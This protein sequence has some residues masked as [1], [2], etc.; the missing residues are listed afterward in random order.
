[1][2]NKIPQIHALG[3][4]DYGSK[5][6]V[7]LGDV[8]S[9]VPAVL[10]TVGKL[11]TNVIPG[12]ITYGVKEAV[13]AFA[14]Q[15]AQNNVSLYDW[16]TKSGWVAQLQGKIDLGA[17]AGLISMQDPYQINSALDLLAPGYNPSIAKK[18]GQDTALTRIAA[19]LDSY[20]R[21]ILN[22]MLKGEFSK[23]GINTLM[24]LGEGFNMLANL[25]KAPLAF[26]GNPLYRDA[27]FEDYDTALSYVSQVAQG[28][29][30]TVYDENGDVA[31]YKVIDPKT[32]QIKSISTE[33]YKS[34]SLI[35][36]TG[37][38]ANI[39][40]LNVWERLASSIGAGDNGRIEYNFDSGSL[41]A[42][43]IGE[44]AVDPSTWF[45]FGL[46]SLG[47]AG[48]KATRAG[49]KDALKIAGS[50]SDEIAAGIMRVGEDRI[51]AAANKFLAEK[52]ISVAAKSSIAPVLERFL[53]DA[54]NDAAT[55]SF[56]IKNFDDAFNAAM[57]YHG[58]YTKATDM[59]II[60]LIN[61]AKATQRARMTNT[62]LRT[63]ETSNDV[64]GKVMWW[65]GG[66]TTGLA[67]TVKLLRGT[68]KA[69]AHKISQQ[70]DAAVQPYLDKQGACNIMCYDDVTRIFDQAMD[71]AAE[72][73]NPS[74]LAALNDLYNKGALFEEQSNRV[75]AQINSIVASKASAKEQLEQLKTVLKDAYDTTSA[76]KVVAQYKRVIKQFPDAKYLQEAV[77]TLEQ[78]AKL[79]KYLTKSAKYGDAHEIAEYIFTSLIKE[80]PADASKIYQ[81]PIRVQ[82]SNIREAISDA[83]TQYIGDG[84]STVLTPLLVRR[85]KTTI[86]E[87][88]KNAY[89]SE[90]QRLHDR[91]LKILPNEASVIKD[92]FHQYTYPKM[93]NDY[94]Q[95]IDNIERTLDEK[96]GISLAEFEPVL[97]KEL[98][99]VDP[100]VNTVYRDLIT[101]DAE[102]AAAA[103]EKF[104]EWRTLVMQNILATK[105]D[106]FVPASLANVQKLVQTANKAQQKLL[107]T[108][109]QLNKDL[110]LPAVKKKGASFERPDLQELL[111]RAADEA[112]DTGALEDVLYSDQVF[113]TE[114]YELFD[115]EYQIENVEAFFSDNI[116][117]ALI[118]P[119]KHVS[120]AELQ[121]YLENFKSIE[122]QVQQMRDALNELPEKT[123]ETM[124]EYKKQGWKYTLRDPID[125][126]PNPEGHALRLAQLRRDVFTLRAEKLQQAEA[127][128][129]YYDI[130]NY[131]LDA[132]Q[133]VLFEDMVE[134]KLTQIA[135]TDMLL[136][137]TSGLTDLVSL[138]SS[139]TF[140]KFVDNLKVVKDS[141]TELYQALNWEVI[142]KGVAAASQIRTQVPAMIALRN[143][144][145]H[146]IGLSDEQAIALYNAIT[147]RYYLTPDQVATSYTAQTILEDA[148]KNDMFTNHSTRRLSL[149]EVG[150]RDPETLNKLRAQNGFA[151]LEDGV[152]E[153]HIAAEDSI[154][155]FM[156][157][158]ELMES[159]SA[160][161]AAVAGKRTVF[162]DIETQNEK[163][164]LQKNQIHSVAIME[165][166]AA[167]NIVKR[168][169]IALDAGKTTVNVNHAMLGKL[170]PDLDAGARAEQ[171]IASLSKQA[172]DGL[173]KDST[174]LARAA[175]NYLL[176][177]YDAADTCIIGHNIAAFDAP[178]LN[179][180]VN[181]IRYD[182]STQLFGY[183]TVDTYTAARG[184]YAA[185][186]ISFTTEQADQITA[187]LQIY[188]HQLQQSDVT[189]VFTPITTEQL[190]DLKNMFREFN[191]HADL[192]S[193][194]D[195]ELFNAAKKP[196]SKIGESLNMIRTNNAGLRSV[197]LPKQLFITGN[198]L[199]EEQLQKLVSGWTEYF[200][201]MGMSAEDITAR[202]GDS[203]TALSTTSILGA[204]DATRS[205]AVKNILS[206]DMIKQ[207]FN[208][209][210]HLV[211]GYMP[212][213]TAM[214]LQ[215]TA[216]SL[217]R[218]EQ[219]FGALLNVKAFSPDIR[220]QYLISAD[221][222]YARFVNAESTLFPELKDIL[223]YEQLTD[224]QK[225]AVASYI[226]DRAPGKLGL[227]AEQ[228]FTED[229]IPAGPLW[230]FANRSCP[231]TVRYS[232]M[233]SSLEV[234]R[235]YKQ[236]QI[237]FNANKITLDQLAEIKDA[238][239]CIGAAH[240]VRMRALEPLFDFID[241][242]GSLEGKALITFSKIDIDAGLRRSKLLIADVLHTPPEQMKTRLA[243][244]HGVIRI[245]THGLQMQEV[246]EMLS[247]YDTPALQAAGVYTY[248]DEQ[249]NSIWFTLDAKAGINSTID[250]DLKRARIYTADGTELEPY[251]FG[252]T[253][254]AACYGAVKN[255]YGAKLIDTE[256]FEAAEATLISATDGALIG[257]DYTL[258]TAERLK[259]LYESMPKQVRE[260]YDYNTFSKGAFFKT[261]A[262]NRSDLS[263]TSSPLTVKLYDAAQRTME[264]A[265]ADTLY[266]QCMFSDF[267]AI[268][269]S[270]I[271]GNLIRNNPADVA[272][273]F[274]KNGAYVGASLATRRDGTV[275][276]KTYDLGNTAELQACLKEGGQIFDYTEYAQIYDVINNHMWSDA[277]FKAWRQVMAVYKIGTLVNP[278]TWLR[279]IEDTLIKNME[280]T[281]DVAVVKY[282][283]KAARALSAF[284]EHAKN[285]TLARSAGEVIDSA[286][287]DAYF[288]GS[289]NMTRAEYDEIQHLMGIGVFGGETKT[290]T[291][292]EREHQKKLLEGWLKDQSIDLQTY[293]KYAIQA[294]LRK[295]AS[296]LLAPMEYTENIARYALYYALK[297][298]GFGINA[299]AKKIADTHFDYAN[300][301]ALEHTMEYIM[302]F[303]TFQRRNLNYWLGVAEDNP[304]FMAYLC[305]MLEPLMD[306]G[307]YSPEDLE[308]NNL[309]QY[310]VLAG[311]I[312]LSDNFYLNTSFSFMDACNRITDILGSRK[313]SVFNPLNILI[314]VALQGG[315]DEAYRS[316]YDMLSNWMQNAFG[317]KMTEE[318]VLAKY[319]TWTENF[320]ALT[321]YEPSG[322]P[323]ENLKRKLTKNQQWLTLIPAV[324]TQM[325]RFWKTAHFW[326]D[327][328]VLGSLLS[329]AG[330]GNPIPDYVQESS[331]NYAAKKAQYRSWLEVFGYAPDTYVD[332]YGRDIRTM[333]LEEL[334]A[335][336]RKVTEEYKEREG[337]DA[338]QPVSAIYILLQDDQ[339]RFLYSRMK[340][341]MGYADTKYSD[342]PDDIKQAL[343]WTLTNQ[344]DLSPCIPILQ[345][346]SVMLPMWRSLASKY[347][348]SLDDI[349]SVPNE[350][351]VQMYSDVAKSVV[352][353]SNI[354]SMLQDERYRA[355][356][357]TSRE[358]LG[359][360]N[361]KLS[362][363]PC[364][365]LEL[366]EKYMQGHP[367]ASRS[368]K[369]RTSG[370]YKT[371][372]RG[373]VYHTMSY[374]NLGTPAFEMRNLNMHGTP[375]RNSY[376]ANKYGVR[377]HQAG[378]RKR[379]YK[380]LYTKS[381]KSRLQLR[382]IPITPD[383]LK[384]RIKDNFYYIN[385]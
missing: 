72:G 77:H 146:G 43:F 57:A 54:S 273:A 102:Y 150:A 249:S 206:P 347:N 180:N 292:L 147:K 85:I 171:Y 82:L 309:V 195:I 168:Y 277:K 174:E 351:L 316:G 90:L 360:E 28:Q 93:Y 362:Q 225:F 303:Y 270:S 42:D 228:V 253:P 335:F 275:L 138:L 21:Y 227:S 383:N 320:Y 204:C 338:D 39:K 363:L 358:M 384:Y 203:L 80:D 162:V 352:T 245:D 343:Y 53:K 199:P 183:Q 374:S 379:F 293:T 197:P 122:R 242:V 314:D 66:L 22:P 322:T 45:T 328:H 376:T 4:G 359:L 340:A 301:T 89:V 279:N 300:K 377:S 81:G 140:T 323:I 71:N 142:D 357:K 15:A 348:V 165:Y 278:G 355:A 99:F 302:P 86:L 155:N 219:Q 3:A 198:A 375:Q 339:K 220:A 94:V 191:E 27:Y 84:F 51:F 283:F 266:K 134:L 116:F 251:A 74:E 40:D 106:A 65:A 365:I 380:N 256:K 182:D 239:G 158:K 105:A 23:V 280:V 294:D 10:N 128:L 169:T 59:N 231:D 112:V 289:K 110:N 163:T 260:H 37:R 284:E 311:N 79:K 154:N 216:K 336:Y 317:L 136:D 5:N 297:D 334:K 235:I 151:P 34:Y 190:T 100:R 349:D 48:V 55:H 188:A 342:L 223:P 50:Q 331:L 254:A 364:D 29:C 36:N 217:Q 164:A 285:I 354:T 201:S 152:Y 262:F 129:K 326:D 103:A 291:K 17:D 159:D 333:S 324:G 248:I 56:K 121:V 229:I 109:Q 143:T 290:F 175:R 64:L 210:P 226:V 58:I 148:V 104:A 131:V 271:L 127:L 356:Y 327:E 68:N 44:V 69:V 145:M 200:K 16:M 98:Y 2:A 281:G 268:K 313:D 276:I 193:K 250:T 247:A 107:Q 296:W 41:L 318:Q 306:V 232:D 295:K 366:I 287:L 213:K 240:T 8:A 215:G 212:Y 18:Y 305:S 184:K 157:H 259:S 282:H 369:R 117:A 73:L 346:Q 114:L 160:Y 35:V 19:G 246:K 144:I 38:T 9:Q 370:Y 205:L 329:L 196:I 236:A 181:D 189:A 60:R 52:E 167:G 91:L 139:G 298:Q 274:R 310:H 321:N 6:K 26:K 83:I 87:P 224:S 202:F 372:A 218:R 12:I 78:A 341:A 269:N 207:W 337:L 209:T 299:I 319:G 166:D 367:A 31:Y 265:R 111:T 115:K 368:S 119:D 361:L 243:Y 141:N 113:F 187:L 286:W 125:P 221:Q 124:S 47:K 315:A 137:H 373:R 330:I 332:E 385:R 258:M 46:S 20:K 264:M 76:A 272:K 353:I 192:Y 1:M 123:A 267:S 344:T 156:L 30:E 130:S 185:G 96:V 173:Y 61:K 49:V 120:E 25:I 118:N 238:N 382:M 14:P 126:D 304:M 63:V 345:D 176:S 230:F 211:D 178:I 325:Q 186:T 378:Y 172:S 161:A 33:D 350:T 234:Y 244:S 62:I 263:V 11:V 24:S 252:R 179:K 95:L 241:S 149:E 67:P 233:L 70:L 101:K 133:L 288:K 222:L 194:A 108:A 261:L 32:N 13:N 92:A 237:D 214:V 135:Q 255:A 75:C 371:G 170:Y 177:T 257:S 7:T 153:T 381:G 308:N 307:Q 97:N 88:A 312:K 208:V 132:P